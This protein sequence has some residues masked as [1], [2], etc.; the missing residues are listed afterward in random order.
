MFWGFRTQNRNFQESSV[1]VPRSRPQEQGFG[2]VWKAIPRVTG[3]GVKQELEGN[4]LPAPLPPDTWEIVG[5]TALFGQAGGLLSAKGYSSLVEVA[6]RALA[7][8]HFWSASWTPPL[9][10]T[11]LS[12]ILR[13]PWAESQ[14]LCRKMLL[15]SSQR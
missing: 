15:A 2:T 5:D 10:C 1:R 4:H 9:S 6:P 3:W 11:P 13:S 7:S 8:G 14:G 12:C